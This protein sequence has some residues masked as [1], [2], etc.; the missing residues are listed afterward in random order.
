MLFLESFSK[1]I[2]KLNY[3]QEKWQSFKYID[4][5]M[6]PSMTFKA[7][8]HFMKCQSSQKI[9]FN[10]ARKNLAKIR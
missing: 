3:I 5:L 4:D 8:H 2:Q 10:Y 6:R 7:T 9:L 1:I